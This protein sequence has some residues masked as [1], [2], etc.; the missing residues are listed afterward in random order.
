MTYQAGQGGGQYTGNGVG[1]APRDEV[2]VPSQDFNIFSALAW[3]FKRVFS[4]WL[5]WIVFGVIIMAAL[6][7]LYLLGLA[8]MGMFEAIDA[9]ADSPTPQTEKA[10]EDLDNSFQFYALMTVMGLISA[11]V[12]YPLAVHAAV[13]QLNKSQ[14]GISDV[15]EGLRYGPIVGN[16]F[17][18]ALIGAVMYFVV[19][20]VPIALIVVSIFLIESAS[21]QPWGIVLLVLGILTLI[22]AVIAFAIVQ[23]RLFL[24]VFYAA[25]GGV[26]NSLK[27]AWNSS[28]GHRLLLLGFYILSNLLGTVF[29]VVTLGLGMLIWS[30]ISLLG[31]AYLYRQIRGQYESTNAGMPVTSQPQ[32][33]QAPGYQSF[34]GPGYQSYGM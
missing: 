34:Q 25:E 11:L 23:M 5:I 17:L 14:I 8:Q 10:L 26:D 2:V 31:F 16:I 30:Q 19:V 7:G 3:G 9:A 32:Q 20:M 12:I 4:S 21:A 27:A 33:F 13:K 28:K 15:T 29:I 6:V 1:P 22:A 18:I 24:A